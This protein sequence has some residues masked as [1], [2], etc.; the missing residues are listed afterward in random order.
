MLDPAVA[1][2]L[3]SFANVSLHANGAA[4]PNF[5]LPLHSHSGR[6]HGQM[7]YKGS[8]GEMDRIDQNIAIAQCDIGP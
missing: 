8:L 2:N 6:Q 4:D 5:G 1:L 7:P 3:R